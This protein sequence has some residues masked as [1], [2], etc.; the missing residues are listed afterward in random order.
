MTA[1]RAPLDHLTHLERESARFADVV[2]LGPTDAAVTSCP[3]WDLRKL[4]LH[5]GRVQRWATIAAATGVEPDREVFRSAPA[6]DQELGTWLRNGTATLVETLR[7]VD[8]DTPTWHLFPGVPLV[9][10]IWRRRQA[11]EILVH[12]WDAEAAIGRTTPLD[13]ELASDGIDEYFG[14][15]LPR[16]LEREQLAVPDSTLHVHCTDVAGEWLVQRG[17][18]GQLDVLREHAKGT[19]ALRGPAAA[20]LLH[21]WGRRGGDGTID[22]AGDADAASDW[23][24]L[25][26]A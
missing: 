14:V 4:G 20:L 23:L 25:G 13:A 7:A 17:G 16:L 5:I 12:R 24:A 15:M 2:E 26:G 21:L 9:A 19:A 8:P 11:H 3:G 1:D 18:D 6:D 22:I 10:G